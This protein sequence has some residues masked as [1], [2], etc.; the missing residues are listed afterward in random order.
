[1]N[2]CRDG[3]DRAGKIS[4]VYIPKTPVAALNK[5]VRGPIAPTSF[6]LLV[7]HILFRRC[8]NNPKIALLGSIF[9]SI[10]FQFP[11][12]SGDSKIYNDYIPSSFHSYNTPIS[13]L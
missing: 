12:Q 5:F 2:D 6:R 13:I 3:G 8:S 11:L 4:L 1:K 10:S 9:Y 7:P